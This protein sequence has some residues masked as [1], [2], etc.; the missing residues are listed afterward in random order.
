MGLRNAAALELVWIGGGYYVFFHPLYN[1][2]VHPIRNKEYVL[3]KTYPASSVCLCCSCVCRDACPHVCCQRKNPNIIPQVLSIFSSS[4][5]LLFLHFLAWRLPSQLAGQ[6]ATRICVS[7]S[8][9]PGSGF[10][11]P[12]LLAAR[13]SLSHNSD[14]SHPPALNLSVIT[15]Y[16]YCT[17]LYGQFQW[18]TT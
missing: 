14:L 4:F 5:F 16:C 15:L 9:L 1:A 3:K 18:L 2:F 17:K 12:A 7:P 10:Q 11:M 13:R 6:L 8:S